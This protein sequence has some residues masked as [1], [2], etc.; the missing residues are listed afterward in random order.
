MESKY[1]WLE[2]TDQS[3]VDET[4]RKVEKHFGFDRTYIPSEHTDLYEK[5]GYC[6]LKDIVNYG[7]GTDRL[8]VK[9]L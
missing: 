2:R 7:N 3:T 4:V 6:Y 8:Y 9:E 1:F 5:F